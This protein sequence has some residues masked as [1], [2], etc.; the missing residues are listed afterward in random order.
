VT[1]VEAKSKKQQPAP[2]APASFEDATQRLA[3]IV[4]RLE[5]GD[6]P[7]EESLKLFEEGVHLSRTAQ[8]TLDAAEKRIEEL[9][10]VDSTGA[11]KTRAFETTP[12]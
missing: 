1:L 8:S 3:A 11:A 10:S 4:T 9:L 2:D 6:L 5:S 12:E 7:L